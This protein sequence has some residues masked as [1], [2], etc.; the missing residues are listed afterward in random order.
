[1]AQNAQYDPAFG[2][3]ARR[4]KRD[5]NRFAVGAVLMIAIAM[6]LALPRRVRR[7]REQKAVNTEL[8]E[9]QAHIRV[10]QGR[11]VEVEQKITATQLEIK[12]LQSSSP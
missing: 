2:E 3:V 10:M 8:L 6:A 9:L 5:R 11:V 4:L 7:Y 1:M 12:K